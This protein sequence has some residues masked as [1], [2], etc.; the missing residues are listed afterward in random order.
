MPTYLRG[1]VPCTTSPCMNGARVEHPK[2]VLFTKGHLHCTCL[3]FTTPDG[4]RLW[5]LGFSG[6]CSTVLPALP[7]HRANTNKQDPQLMSLVNLF[8]KLPPDGSAARG[9]LVP[10]PVC[11]SAVRVLFSLRPNLRFPTRALDPE[12]LRLLGGLPPNR[13]QGPD[14]TKAAFGL[15]AFTTGPPMDI[16]FPLPHS[17]PVQAP[18]QVDM[19][20]SGQTG[21]GSDAPSQNNSHRMDSHT[22]ACLIFSNYSLQSTSEGL[23]TP[24]AATNLNPTHTHTA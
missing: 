7:L 2:D 21:G 5:N 24:F 23:P 17:A 11:V 9:R 14:S 10:S 13:G 4:R 1:T 20:C 12:L 16:C 22:N 6:F 15:G 18:V 19:A 8:Q 3:V